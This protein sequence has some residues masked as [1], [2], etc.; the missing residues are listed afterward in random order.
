MAKQLNRHQGVIVSKNLK[1]ENGNVDRFC[2]INWEKCG[3]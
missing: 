2:P 3:D 1:K